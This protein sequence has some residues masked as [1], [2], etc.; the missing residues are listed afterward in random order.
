MIPWLAPPDQALVFN[1]LSFETPEQQ[2]DYVRA[3]ARKR[4]G[5]PCDFK[6]AFYP[7][8]YAA[9][10]CS[11]LPVGDPTSYIPDNEV[12]STGAHC[13]ALYAHALTW[14]RIAWGVQHWAEACG[15]G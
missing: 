3:W 11:I 9:E 15:I 7:G 2:E 4:T 13:Q 5:L 12:R 6:V 14:L 10:K 1:N 8:R